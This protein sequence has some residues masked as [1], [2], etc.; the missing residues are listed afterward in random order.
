MKQIGMD[1]A[2]DKKSK[3]SLY[4]EKTQINVSFFCFTALTPEPAESAG[5]GTG[6]NPTEASSPDEIFLIPFSTEE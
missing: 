5:Q 4:K 1:E 3:F 2:K 6:D